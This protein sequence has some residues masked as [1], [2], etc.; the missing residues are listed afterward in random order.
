MSRIEYNY[1]ARVEQLTDNLVQAAEGQ[2]AMTGTVVMD[3]WGRYWYSESYWHDP[4][5]IIT[6]SRQVEEWLCVTDLPR[7]LN[8]RVTALLEA[9]LPAG[10]PMSCGEY[11]IYDQPKK[12]RP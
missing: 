2:H 4:T 6:H 7:N 11:S 8:H 12:E 9:T 1:Q 5:Y 10:L 3:N